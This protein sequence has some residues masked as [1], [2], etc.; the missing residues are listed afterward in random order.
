MINR[1]YNRKKQQVIFI[2]GP[3][4]VG[5]TRIAVSLA[6]KIGAE[7][8][9]VDSMQVYKGMQI[10]T[11]APDKKTAGKIKYHL[12]GTIPPTRQYNV[13]R[14]RSDALRAMKGIIRRKKTPLFVG[15]TG[16]YVSVLLDG[17]FKQ[18]AQDKQLRQRLY[19]EAG[20]LGAG[21]L[22]KRLKIVDPIAA[23]KIH[24]NDIRRIA[25]ALEVFEVTG[26]PISELQKQRRGLAD[27]FNVKIF[28]INM[29]RKKLYEIID[30]RLD[31]MFREG[32][33]KEV[34]KLLKSRL[35]KTASYAI[36]IR[37]IKGYLDGLYDLK[38]ARQLMKHNTHLYAKRQLTW[39]RKDRRINWVEIKPR[40]GAR[41]VVGVIISILKSK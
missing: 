20:K 41:E 16:L 39:F 19:E 24:P 37:E 38:Q 2:V 34:K 14:Y 8:I 21:T 3:T 32:A 40:Q 17:L 18:K 31:K 26:K 30:K 13:S 35:S 10:I 28:C 27:E 11:S 7:I 22:H 25:R 5:K 23:K 6:K 33:A 1:Q 12:I 4:A 36:G 29:D 9:S 15:G